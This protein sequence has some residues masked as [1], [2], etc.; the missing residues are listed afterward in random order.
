MNI[1]V[2]N[3]TAFSR[4]FKFLENH[5][6]INVDAP[7]RCG[8]KRITDTN[9]NNKASTQPKPKKIRR[10]YVD[11]QMSK[12]GLSSSHFNNFDA[13]NNKLVSR[14]RPNP[15]KLVPCQTFDDE[16]QVRVLIV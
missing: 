2:G 4:I 15:F 13:S 9:N 7:R 10:S 3:V 1:F 6:A 12:L 8:L 5:R 11:N 16:T 14:T